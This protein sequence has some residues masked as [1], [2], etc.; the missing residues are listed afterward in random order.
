VRRTYPESPPQSIL[1]VDVIVEYVLYCSHAHCTWIGLD[2]HG[3]QRLV[4]LCVSKC[5]VSHTVVVGVGG[6]RSNGEA[7]GIVDDVVVS[8]DI[9]CTSAVLPI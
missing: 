8:Q 7:S 3:L 9:S 5:N 4:H 2:V 6:D 1:D